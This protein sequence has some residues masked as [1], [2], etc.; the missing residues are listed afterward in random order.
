MSEAFSEFMKARFPS[1]NELVR[2]DE[3]GPK[4]IDTWGCPVAITVTGDT[5]RLQLSD[6]LVVNR[7]IEDFLGKYRQP[8]DRKLGLKGTIILELTRFQAQRLEEL[9]SLVEHVKP[10]RHVKDYGPYMMMKDKTCKA[11]N[12][13]VDALDDFEE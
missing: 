10:D 8:V 12:A 9:P 11:L 4:G 6:L 5:F 13:L 3:L 1:G 2:I 7:E